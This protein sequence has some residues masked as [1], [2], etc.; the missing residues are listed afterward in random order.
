MGLLPKTNSVKSQP[1]AS[2]NK[3][4][5]LQ[6]VTFTPPDAGRRDFL[7]PT[8][9]NGCVASYWTAAF[10]DVPAEARVEINHV[11]VEGFFGRDFVPLGVVTPPTPPP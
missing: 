6:E 5:P 11:V 8:V 4:L 10:V 2:A 9:W 3:H 7:S 1:A